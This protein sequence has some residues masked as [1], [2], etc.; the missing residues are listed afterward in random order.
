MLNAPNAGS[1]RRTLSTYLLQNI[2]YCFRASAS[3]DCWHLLSPQPHQGDWLRCC[4]AFQSPYWI[5]RATVSWAG[6]S[7]AVWLLAKWPWL[8]C[9]IGQQLSFFTSAKRQPAP[10]FSGGPLVKTPHFQCKGEG[11]NPGRETK[12]PHA[13]WP[14]NKN[15]YLNI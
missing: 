13:I 2:R 5:F 8:D 1:E 3:L 11:S 4:S 12:V 10:D 14:T 6:S 15:K 9:P 7:Q